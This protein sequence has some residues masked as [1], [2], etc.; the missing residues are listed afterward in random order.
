MSIDP[1]IKSF[2]AY[3]EHGAKQLQLTLS[4][5]QLEALLSYVTLLEKW[6]KHYNLSAIRDT[7][8]IITHHILDS[9]SVAPY[10]ANYHRVL[11]VGTGAGLPGIVLA[12]CFPEH[13]F[14]LLDSNGKKI[15]FLTQVK[16]DLKI[17]NITLVC[18]RA[19]N[20]QTEPCFDAIISRALGSMSELI[21]T[22]KQLLCS[23]GSWCAMK[24]MYPKSELDELVLPYHVQKLIVPG[25]DA[26]RHL[27]IISNT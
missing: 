7:K 22:T 15:R 6:N 1:V 20:Y 21:Q 19:E 11:D 25:L 3:L 8:Q 4:S 10:M 24:G 13:H 5:V 12:L 9:L 17:N 2:Y 27:V 18:T 16:Y 14:S 23:S 26:S